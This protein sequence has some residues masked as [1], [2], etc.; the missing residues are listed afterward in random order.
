MNFCPL[1]QAQSDKIKLQ[2]RVEELQQKYEPKG[3]TS[4][5]THIIHVSF[6]FSNTA[7]SW[8]LSVEAKKNVIQKK[9]KEKFPVNF[10]PSSDETS[11]DK[12]EPIVTMSTDKTD[13]K[14][15][16]PKADTS[17]NKETLASTQGVITG[18]CVM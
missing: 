11:V 18:T 1:L 13:A 12:G 16:D 14:T 4:Y 5:H 6:T 2:L 17:P 8:T 7:S 10:A 9:K 15:A 3:N